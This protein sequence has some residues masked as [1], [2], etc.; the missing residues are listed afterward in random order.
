[1]TTAAWEAVARGA[2]L[3]DAEAAQVA[4]DAEAL[5]EKLTSTPSRS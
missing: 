4:R 3:S 5:V 2:G 1:M